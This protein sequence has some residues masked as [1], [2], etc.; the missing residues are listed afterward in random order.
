M[1]I[2]FVYINMGVDQKVLA[3]TV[4]FENH[5]QAFVP[6]KDLAKE[7]AKE[8]W[9]HKIFSETF[10]ESCLYAYKYLQTPLPCSGP[11]WASFAKDP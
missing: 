3:R 5:I 4:T 10:S 1:H 11:F 7:S 6:A 2:Y 8:M 9:F